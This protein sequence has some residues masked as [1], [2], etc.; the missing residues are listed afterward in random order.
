M[1]KLSDKKHFSLDTNASITEQQQAEIAALNAMLD[2]AI[3]F[4]DIAPLSEKFWQTCRKVYK[5]RYQEI[6]K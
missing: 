5:H 3:D 2:E 1:N 4:S 6:K